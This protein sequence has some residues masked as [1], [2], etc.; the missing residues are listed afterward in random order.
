MKSAKTWSILNSIILLLIVGWNYTANSAGVDGNTVASLSDR[1]ANLFTPAGYAFGIWGVIYLSLFA[2]CTFLVKSAFSTRKYDAL[3]NGIGPGLA[4]VNLLN[5]L[6]LY[7]WLTEN[8]LVSLFLMFGMLLMLLY[9][10]SY[11][12]QMKWDRISVTR[13][14]VWWP[15]SLYGGWITVASIANVS[16]LLA[17]NGISPVLSEVTWTVVMIGIA[18]VIYYMTVRLRKMTLFTAV[19]IW[20]LVAIAWRHY[21]EIAV[22]FYTALACSFFLLVAIVKNTWLG[23]DRNHSTERT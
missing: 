16:A 10:L 3:I 23:G 2:L 17:K 13:Q 19:G 15:L 9:L 5:G 22:I 6:W 12:H 11:L 7:A 8:T 18:T 20:A 14:A 21:G 4:I 1:Y